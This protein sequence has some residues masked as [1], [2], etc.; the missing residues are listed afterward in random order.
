MTRSARQRQACHRAAHAAGAAL[1]A[2]LAALPARGEVEVDGT[3][4]KITKADCLRLVKH[5][6]DPGVAYQPGVDVR[7][8]PVE[9]ADLYD[10]PRIE[11]PQRLQIPIEVDLGA[12]YD[13][14]ADDSF[15]GDVQVGTVEVDLETGRATFNGQP[16]TSG[17][18][19]ALRTRC[20]KVLSDPSDRDE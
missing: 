5:R 12:R 15:K 20:Q 6:P 16:L 4:V 3:L 9:G 8:N 1:F 19:E 18:E 14:P 11:L 7:G 13:L 17:A 2:M 10:R